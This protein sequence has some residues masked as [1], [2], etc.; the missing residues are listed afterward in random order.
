MFFFN[1]PFSSAPKVE[2]R[3]GETDPELFFYEL[4]SM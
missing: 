3:E 1:V 4:P 2:A